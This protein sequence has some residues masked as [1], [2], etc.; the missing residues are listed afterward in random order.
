MRPTATLALVLST[1]LARP[2][3][4]TCGDS[5]TATSRASAV[6][7]QGIASFG[8]A[9]DRDWLYLYGGHVGVPHSHSLDDLSTSFLRLNLLDRRTWESLP[10]RTP[11]QGTALVAYGGRLYRA[12][13]MTATNR[14]GDEENL[15]SRDDFERFDP[16]ARSW[17]ALPPLPEPRSSHDAVVVDGKI[18]VMGGWTLTAQGRTWRRS[19]YFADLNAETPQWTAAEDAPFERRAL[20]LASVGGEVWALG[21]ITPEGELSQEVDVFDPRSRSWSKGPKLPVAGFGVAALGDGDAL[22][23]SGLDGVVYALERGAERWNPLERLL[24][25]RFFHRIV[26]GQEGE[27]LVV[28]GA[29]GGSHSR[30]VESLRLSREPG[31]VGALDPVVADW[32]IP[33]PGRA[34][35]RQGVELRGSVLTVYGGNDSLAQHDFEPQNFVDEAFEIHLATL[36]VEAIASLPSP[37]QSLATVH[38]GGGDSTGPHRSARP[39]R[40]E[41]LLAVGGFG[42]D[43]SRARSFDGVWRF[44]LRAGRWTTLDARLDRP[45]TQFQLV[46]HGAKVWAFGGLDYD[47]ER[48]GER[49]EFRHVLEIARWDPAQPESGFSALEHRLPRPR[50]A[51][52]GALLDGKFVLAGGLADAFEP[53]TVCDVWDFA[54][55][56]W[57]EIPAPARPRI[58]PELVALDGRLWLAGGT[59]RRDDGTFA[60]EESI[61][62]YDP[63]TRAWSVVLA[64]APLEPRHVHAREFGGRLLLYSV[65]R[66]DRALRI[67]VIDPRIALANAASAASAAAT[68]AASATSPAAATGSAP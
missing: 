37:R 45:R 17:T 68:S 8:A 9:T 12:G 35:N 59:S 61:E 58:S 62:V 65:H 52:G 46:E 64:R 20:A 2:T 63:A 31:G 28:G 43:G 15:R 67:V 41:A 6:L 66:H 57:S 30:V 50:R 55:A 7:P 21:G 10:M 60:P 11:A 49:D 39:A 44:D 36:R 48:G 51:F 38:L 3:A 23:A 47:P 5:L 32:T 24:V 14:R 33:F 29:S 13:G 1:T 18:W 25:A 26:P 27:L 22:I 19:V 40:D 4:A 54:T 34:R 16:L 56:T 53:V 42:H